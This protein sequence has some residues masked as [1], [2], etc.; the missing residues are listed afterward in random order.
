M[1]R[2]AILSV[3]LLLACGDDDGMVGPDSG[4]TNPNARMC[5][6]TDGVSACSGQFCSANEWCD[7]I[8]CEA[9]CQSSAN[10]AAGMFCDKNGATGIDGAGVCRTCATPM[11]DA[12]PGPAR[13][14]GPSC[15][16]V[17]GNYTVRQTA[18]NPGVCRM[19]DVE[20]LFRHSGRQ[21]CHGDRQ[22]RRQPRIRRLHARLRRVFLCR[23]LRCRG[24][25]RKRHLDAQR[26]AL[27]PDGVWNHLQ[28]RCFGTCLERLG[29]VT[30]LFFESP[31]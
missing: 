8:I 19:L 26:R 15:S 23:N 12:G 29:A 28:L 17:T 11:P 10:C 2:F 27:R 24:I 18:G 7:V 22:H 9:G 1:T 31:R 6:T 5:S 14:S 16:D 25:E 13:D 30:Q 4:S 20:T 3:F 21:R